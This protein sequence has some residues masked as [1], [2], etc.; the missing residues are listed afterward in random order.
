MKK[1]F[2]ACLLALPACALTSTPA[3]AW[4]CGSCGGCDGCGFNIGI[5]LTFGFKF[6]C[7]K[8]CPPC[9]APCGG[10]SFGS[11]GYDGGYGYA[12]YGVDGYAY[13]AP[14]YGY[15]D[16]AAGGSPISSFSPTQSASYQQPTSYPSYGFMPV[17]YQAPSYWYGR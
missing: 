17:N 13:G 15:T 12:G 2:V 5:G 7:Q 3:E 16:A 11:G 4:G 6:S 14:A 8:A 10:C 1:F 9:G